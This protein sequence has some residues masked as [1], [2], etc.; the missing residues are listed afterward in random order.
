[1][2]VEIVGTEPREVE[3]IPSLWLVGRD[4][5]LWP[6]YKSMNSATKAIKGREIPKQSWQ[7]YRARNLMEGSK[8]CY[9]C[10]H[11]SLIYYELLFFK[12][13][14]KYVCKYIYLRGIVSY[15]Y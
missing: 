13:T 8:S 14:H 2:I 15:S 7:K 10:I 6:P 4:Y 5:C 9:K 1:M 3:A 12:D 11:L